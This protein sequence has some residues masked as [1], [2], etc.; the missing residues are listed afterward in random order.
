LPSVLCLKA[1]KIL[2]IS[3][4]EY[5]HKSEAVPDS[6]NFSPK[7]SSSQFL[8]NNKITFNNFFFKGEES[9]NVEYG[10]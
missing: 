8:K 5:S 9:N 1:K 3:S 10:L 6:F 7:Y 2:A 4:S